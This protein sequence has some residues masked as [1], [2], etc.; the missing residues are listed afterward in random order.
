MLFGP[1]LY[2]SGLETNDG[3]PTFPPGMSQQALVT[4]AKSYDLSAHPPT[5]DWSKALQHLPENDILAAVGSPHGIYADRTP[6]GK[7]GMIAAHTQ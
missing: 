2:D 6:S 1:W 4:A 5:V 3:R 7:P